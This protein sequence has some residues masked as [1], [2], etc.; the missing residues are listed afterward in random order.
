M[1]KLTVVGSMNLDLV[2]SVAHLP[3]PGETVLGSDVVYRAGGKGANQAAAAR[4]L[5]ADVKLFALSGDDHFGADLRN[6][7]ADQGLDITGVG[8][9]DDAATGVALIVVRPDGENTITVAQGANRL[10]QINRLG[11][12][13]TDLSNSDAVLLQLEIPTE[14]DIAVARIAAETNTLS[15]LNAA[16]L[17]PPDHDDSLDELLGVIDVLVV[18]EIEAF[19]LS[20]EKYRDPDDWA[21]LAST[22]CRLGPSIVVITLGERGAVAASNGATFVQPGFDAD[23]IDRTGAG[24]AFCGALAVALAEHSDVKE[25]LRRGCATGALATTQIGAQ[26]AFP[27]VHEVS[28]LLAETER[29]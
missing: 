11:G 5:G 23:A 25:A 7:L 4:R 19:R 22:M 18:N 28:Q 10:L 1:T 17:S 14:T 6:R 27:N 24:D 29:G 26:A 3:S 8:T 9:V 13:Y 16:P 20:E 2:V 15:V 12:I 21:E